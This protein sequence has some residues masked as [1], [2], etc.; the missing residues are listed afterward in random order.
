MG[1]PA[2]RRQA[3]AHPCRSAGRRANLPG[4]TPHILR[5]GGDLDGAGGCSD[6]RNRTDARAP[7]FAHHRAGLCQAQP[8]LPAPGRRRLASVIGAEDQA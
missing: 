4:M 2:D 8:G 1:D 6:D 5:H 3:D 7:R